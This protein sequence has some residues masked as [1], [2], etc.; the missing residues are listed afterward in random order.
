MG[1]NSATG[2]L[3]TLQPGQHGN[4]ASISGV[5]TTIGTSVGCSGDGWSL[6]REP[7]YALKYEVWS[8]DSLVYSSLDSAW[9]A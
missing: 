8:D 9:S 6:T 4:I 5:G 3:R 2:S 1:T 7:M